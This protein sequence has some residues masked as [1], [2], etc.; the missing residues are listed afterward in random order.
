VRTLLDIQ[1]DLL[2]ELLNETG[3]RTKKEAVT[4]A[5]KAYLDIKRRERLASLMGNYEFG[6]DL[7][8]LERSR[9]DRG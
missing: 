4:I 8:E 1:D 5:I 6:Y 7:R 3:S 9:E 2:K